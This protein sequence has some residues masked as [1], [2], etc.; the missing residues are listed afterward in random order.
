[1]SNSWNVF[2]DLIDNGEVESLLTQTF[3]NSVT[4]DEAVE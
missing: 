2:N 3:Y 4:D 1:M